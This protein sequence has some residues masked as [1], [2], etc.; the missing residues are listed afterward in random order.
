MSRLASRSLNAATGTRLAIF[1]Q[2]TG[3]TQ[4]EF[5]ATVELSLRGYQNYERGDRELPAVII[6]RLHK[7]WRM[8]PVWLLDGPD[9]R[10]PFYTTDV[11]LQLLAA[12]HRELAARLAGGNLMP[13]FDQK[14]RLITPLYDFASKADVRSAFDAVLAS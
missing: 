7:M 4:K 10:S 8:D 9:D 2:R 3:L 14:V 13:T 5:G 11:D 12:I 1:R 6:S